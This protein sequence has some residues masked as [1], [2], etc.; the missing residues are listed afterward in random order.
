[1]LRRQHL[2]SR[3]SVVHSPSWGL[4]LMKVSSPRPV[5]SLGESPPPRPSGQSARLRSAPRGAAD[6]SRACPSARGQ[7][8]PNPGAGGRRQGPGRR[9]RGSRESA[10]EQCVPA[11][12]RPVR[13]VPPVEPAHGHYSRRARRARR[14]ARRA[15]LLCSRPA[16]RPRSRG[17]AE[18]AERPVPSQAPA[19]GAPRVPGRGFWAPPAGSPLRTAAR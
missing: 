19:G 13:P 5:P 4:K 10:P 7:G 3:K 17:G 16:A 14:G 11:S 15:A 2:A 9:A 18:G 8:R 1:M 6:R 12:P